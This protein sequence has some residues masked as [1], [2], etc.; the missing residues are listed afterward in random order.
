V[1]QGRRE[2]S[3][4]STSGAGV[5]ARSDGRRCPTAALTSSG[6]ASDAAPRGEGGR[7]VCANCARPVLIAAMLPPVIRADGTT[8]GGACPEWPCPN[9]LMM[10]E[11]EGRDKRGSRPVRGERVG[12]LLPTRRVAHRSLIQVRREHHPSAPRLLPAR[13]TEA[14]AESKSSFCLVFME[15]ASGLEPP[16]C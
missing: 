7:S 5:S 2:D 16:T 12:N 11:A 1:E 9:H 13:A 8:P 3:P 10:L 6:S 14:G 15:P 4:R